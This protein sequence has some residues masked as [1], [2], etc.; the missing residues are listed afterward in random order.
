MGTTDGECMKREGYVI[1][2][3]RAEGL[4][5]LKERSAVPRCSST[6]HSPALPGVGRT[7]ETPAG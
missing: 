6:R 7:G 4:A 5:L 1:E 2:E 3:G